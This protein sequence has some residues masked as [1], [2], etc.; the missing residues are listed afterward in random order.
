MKKKIS[1]LLSALLIVF[2]IYAQWSTNP[3]VNNPIASLPGE[4]AIPKIATCS[5]GDTYIGFFSNETGNYNVRLQRLNSLGEAIWPSGGIVISTNQSDSWLTDWDMAADN[6]GHCILTWQDIRNGNNNAYAYRISP[7]GLFVWGNNGIALSSNSNFNA[8]P[9]VVATASGNAVFAWMSGEDIILQKINPAGVKQWGENGITLS[10]SNTLTWPQMLP[11]GSDDII[12]KYFDDSGPSYSPT[13]HVYAQRYNASGAP[14]WTSPALISNAGGISA[15]TQIFPF[16]NDGSDGFYIAWHDDRDNN[17]MASVWVNHVNSSGQ[18]TWPANGIE[19]SSASGYNH[20]YPQLALPPGSQEVFVFWNEMNSLQSQK[21]IYGQKFSSSG[22]SLWGNNGMTFIPLSDLSITPLAARNTPTDM[23]L[24]LD[25]A[26][27]G[28]N[29]S[30]YAMRIATD[31]S[32]VWAGQQVP[33]STAAS[34]KVHTVINE[35]Q[36]NQWITAWEDNRNGASDIYAQNLLLDGTLG[37]WDP[38]F[39]SIQG[40]VTLN[41]GN[42]NITQVVVNAGNV[43]TLP[44]PTGIYFMTV[45]TGT[46]TVTATLEGYYPGTQTGVT[47]LEDQSTTGIDFLL[48]PM[49]TTGFISGIVTLEGGS[50]NVTDVTVSTGSY[51]TSPDQG[52]NYILEVPGGTWDVVASLQGY[53]PQIRSSISVTAGNTTSNV[54]FVLVPLPSTGY[55]QGYVTIEGSVYDLTEVTV[56]AGTQTTHP[57]DNG[58][59]YLEIENG[60][61]DVTATHIWTQNAVIQNV[62]VEPG[63]TTTDISFSLVP[64]RRD[65]IVKATD[66]NGNAI[67]P[68]SIQING[69]GQTY[70]TAMLL[71]DSVIVSNVVYGY[72][73]GSCIYSGTG[74]VFADTL[75][76]GNN[77]N[78]HF[79]FVIDQARYQTAN[80]LLLDV[81]PNPSA[82]RSI[83]KFS[84]PAAGNYL[85][86]LI[87]GSGLVISRYPTGRISGG[88]HQLL[89]ALITEHQKLKPGIYV[90]Q[91]SGEGYNLSKKILISKISD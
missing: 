27:S 65:L 72:Y 59:Y 6:T 19:A 69:P 18:V 61:Y 1:L 62:L 91:L 46:Y 75:V 85:L 84:V 3:A 34:S 31:G 87:S 47:V 12:L 4:Q 38:S 45:P 78:M 21:G 53:T 43:S 15:W 74:T 68:C 9:K 58:F 41:G 36:N 50:G 22:T 44:D 55:I 70:H 2:S 7:D 80:P 82:E 60:V 66:Q 79:H 20:F 30:L 67:Y 54:S 49:P 33:V 37:A 64:F 76:D 42:G 29:S 52:G 11:I 24:L 56:I 40:Q 89:F 16:I 57:S 39:G 90:I 48:D 13:R 71:E 23:I 26:T 51:S 35:F 17:Q 32:F 28:V 10:S 88:A 73:Q 14:V 25:V 8:S 5:N 81:I 86:S 77:N 63:L 83:V